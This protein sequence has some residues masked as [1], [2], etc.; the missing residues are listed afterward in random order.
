[1]YKQM[2]RFGAAVTVAAMGL[3]AP[4]AQA[5]TEDLTV[6]NST[7]A[8]AQDVGPFSSEGVINVFGFRGTVLGG[9]VNDDSNP[10][11]YKFA[12][13]ANQQLTLRVDTPE[14]PVMNND[15]MVGLLDPTGVLLAAD[16]DSGPGYDSL[17]KYTIVTPG[18]YV[19]VVAGYPGIAFWLNPPEIT[20]GGSTDFVYQLNIQTQPVPIPAAAALLGSG[21]LGLAGIKRRRSPA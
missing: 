8:T 7:F 4:S 1:M 15:P 12:V 5:A 11:F 20:A 21:L 2:G 3:G 9:L 16:D 17:L 13:A 10:D 6:D 18:T 19:A 14:G